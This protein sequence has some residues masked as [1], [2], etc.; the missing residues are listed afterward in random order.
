MCDT[1]SWLMSPGATCAL[2]NRATA[3]TGPC[4]RL[5]ACAIAS[6]NP[7]SACCIAVPPCPLQNFVTYFV[8]YSTT[9][10]FEVQACISMFASSPRIKTGAKLLTK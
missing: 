10:H 8:T 6:S 2:K 9:P 3:A 7:R 1:S 4:P 5:F